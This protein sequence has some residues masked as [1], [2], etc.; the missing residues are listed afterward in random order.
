MIISDWITGYDGRLM[1]G[2]ARAK[3]IG[4]SIGLF[5]DNFLTVLRNGMIDY[6]KELTRRRQPLVAGHTSIGPQ[7]L[8]P[9]QKAQPQHIFTRRQ[10]CVSQ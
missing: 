4:L 3:N 2:T 1:A 8:R 6:S 5:D 9:R 10:K 7:P